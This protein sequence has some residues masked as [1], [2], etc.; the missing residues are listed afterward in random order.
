M[1]RHRGDAS[2]S[3]LRP[4][5]LLLASPCL[6]GWVEGAEPPLRPVLADE[7]ADLPPL[8][9]PFWRGWAEGQIPPIQPSPTCGVQQ[10]GQIRR[11]GVG[12]RTGSLLFGPPRLMGCSRGAVS[13]PPP[14]AMGGLPPPPFSPWVAPKRKA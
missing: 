1:I 5:P 6:W 14:S 8:S 11:G 4:S 2:S 10:R 9:L 7:G 3:T 12:Q 13:V